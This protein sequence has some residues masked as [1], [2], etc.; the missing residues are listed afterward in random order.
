MSRVIRTGWSVDVRLRRVWFVPDD[1]WM[2]S[3]SPIARY[4][5]LLRSHYYAAIISSRLRI[6]WWAFCQAEPFKLRE[7]RRAGVGHWLRHLARDTA[8]KTDLY[9]VQCCHIDIA[10]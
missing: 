2:F 9:I 10:T 4:T 7:A 1:L 8:A 6:D 3:V 5:C